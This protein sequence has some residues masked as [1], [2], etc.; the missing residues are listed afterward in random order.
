MCGGVWS[1]AGLSGLTFPL[2]S[3][4]PL[5]RL[6]FLPTPPSPSLY[7]LLTMHRISISFTAVAVKSVNL[8]IEIKWTSRLKRRRH[9]SSARAE[10]FSFL[11]RCW[12]EVLEAEES[13]RR[14]ERR[15]NEWKNESH[16][17]PMVYGP[18]FCLLCLTSQRGWGFVWINSRHK[19]EERE[20]AHRGTKGGSEAWEGC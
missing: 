16:L 1:W 12:Q 7:P 5:R 20:G 6:H 13:E 9:A 8:K 19:K 10:V 11:L 17:R 14:K 15:R 2:K 4:S 18:C 3:F